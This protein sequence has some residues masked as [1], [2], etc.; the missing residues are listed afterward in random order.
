MLVTESTNFAMSSFQSSIDTVSNQVAIFL[1][2][3]LYS[4]RTSDL[5]DRSL[6]ACDCSA[7]RL[8]TMSLLVFT[9]QKNLWQDQK[10]VGWI[11]EF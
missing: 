7:G 9:L 8:Y 3:A 5:G 10:E 1:R 4:V 2:V 6:R 11:L